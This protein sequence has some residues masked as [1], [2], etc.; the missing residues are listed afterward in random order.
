MINIFYL[1]NIYLLNN[2]YYLH[3]IT[4]QQEIPQNLVMV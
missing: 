1:I 3:I 2:E 4:S